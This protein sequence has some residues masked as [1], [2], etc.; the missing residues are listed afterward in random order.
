MIAGAAMKTPSPELTPAEVVSIQVNALRGWRDDPRG[1]LQCFLFASPANK[2]VTGP[3]S[4]FARMVASP[5]Y[6]ALT[7]PGWLSVGP[8]EVESQRAAV[9]VA[10]ISNSGAP[11]AFRF[12]LSQ[13]N[14]PGVGPCWM[15]DAVLVAPTMVATAPAQG[16]ND[17]AR[18]RQGPI[19]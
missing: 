9:M 18:W 10:A 3:V 4:H 17:S 1:I 2:Q 5:P 19:E 11:V 16:P 15:T 13:S 6:D 14:V 7:K 8:A 12:L